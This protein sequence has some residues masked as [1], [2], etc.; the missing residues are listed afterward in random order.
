MLNLIWSE[1]IGIRGHSIFPFLLPLIWAFKCF[2]IHKSMC[3]K[4]DLFFFRLIHNSLRGCLLL[5][6]NTQALKEVCRVWGRRIFS[7]VQNRV[8]FR[9]IFLKCESTYLCVSEYNSEGSRV[10]QQTE[11][12]ISLCSRGLFTGVW[13]VCLYFFSACCEKIS[14]PLQASW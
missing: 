4:P 14:C 5:F 10:A 8:F 7:F 1:K 2:Y 3:I 6:Q 9:L 11:C 13:L 12:F